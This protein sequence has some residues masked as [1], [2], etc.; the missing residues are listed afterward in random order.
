MLYK[1]YQ[2]PFTEEHLRNVFGLYGTILDVS[3]KVNSV[4]EV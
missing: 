2:D 1:N 3:I 4:E